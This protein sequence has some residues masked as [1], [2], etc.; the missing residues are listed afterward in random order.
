MSLLQLTGLW[1]LVIPSQ[2]QGFRQ[3]TFP[4][5]ITEALKMDSAAMV[6]NSRLYNY[7]ED[8]VEW[9]YNGKTGL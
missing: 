8:N 1:R 6:E 7:L 2:I 4:L 3:I 5:I 9:Q